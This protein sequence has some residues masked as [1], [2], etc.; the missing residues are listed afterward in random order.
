MPPESVLA[1]DAGTQT[2]RAALVAPD[3]SVRD[4]ATS[5]LRLST[6]QPGW[7]EQD[8][9]RWWAATASNI[10]AVMGRNPGTRVAAVAVCG[11][12]HG[13]VALDA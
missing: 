2:V 3:G 8:P 12:M 7:A 13:V 1:I 4:L 5:R 9:E 11:Q 6:P 10:T